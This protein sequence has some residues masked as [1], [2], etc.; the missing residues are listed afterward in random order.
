MRVRLP[1]VG[2]ETLFP[3]L[4]GT[5][6]LMHGEGNRV[7]QG[8]HGHGIIKA[9]LYVPGPKKTSSPSLCQVIPTRMHTHRLFMREMKANSA[10][11]KR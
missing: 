6:R 9:Y 11:I 4:V 1:K 3:V 8:N 2:T 7:G 5:A 10:V